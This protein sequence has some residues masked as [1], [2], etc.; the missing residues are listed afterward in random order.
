MPSGLGCT[1]QHMD[2]KSQ[3]PFS[4]G[5]MEFNWSRNQLKTPPREGKGL[6]GGNPNMRPDSHQVPEWGFNRPFIRSLMKDGLDSANQASFLE[7]L[8]IYLNLEIEIGVGR[9]DFLLARAARLTACGF[10]GFEVKTSAAVKLV[11]RVYKAKLA[12]TWISDDDARFGLSHLLVSRQVS[13]IHVLFP[14][15]WWKPGHVHRRLFTP[16]FVDL[17]GQHLSPGG[18]LHLRSDVSELVESAHFLIEES[19]LFYPPNYELQELLEPYRPS[20]R[21]RWCLSQGYPVHSLMCVRKSAA[22]I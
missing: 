6:L 10:I 3:E 7:F 16:A 22:G 8:E 15:P 2:S 5:R 19:Q 14:D 1:L 18:L 17:V 11:R 20:H 21:E 4:Q 9:G 13:A 12:N